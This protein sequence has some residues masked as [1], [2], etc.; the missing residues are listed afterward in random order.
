MFAPLSMSRA[1]ISEQPLLAAA[2]SGVDPLYN[3][4]TETHDH[5]NN[6]Y[7]LLYVCSFSYIVQ[8]VDVRSS[9]DEQSHHLKV[10]TTVSS[11][12]QGS[13]T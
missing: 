10:T 3:R 11:Y 9:V 6:K 4:K 7:Y 5:T 8:V 1:T 2:I 12:C 13:P